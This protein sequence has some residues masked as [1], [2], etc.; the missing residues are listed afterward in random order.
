MKMKSLKAQFIGA[1]AMV[2]VA[3]IAMGS[4]TYAWFAMNTE[5]RAQNMTVQAT[6]E[7][8]LIISNVNKSNWSSYADAQ[9]QSATALVPTSHGIDTGEDD[10]WYHNSS[11]DSNNA[12][13]YAGAYTDLTSSL[14]YTNTSGTLSYGI[15]YIEGGTGSGADAGYSAAQDKAYHLK[16]TFFI[17]TSAEE[18]TTTNL[19]IKNVEVTSSGSMIALDASLR[20]AIVAGGN[21]YIYSPIASANGQAPTYTYAVNSNSTSTSTYKP[22]AT[23]T[24]GSGAGAYLAGKDLACTGVTAIPAYTTETPLQVDIYVYYEGEDAACKS[25]NI[26]GVTVDALT[27]AVT[28]TSAAAA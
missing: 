24:G 14:A 5:V 17:K 11:K 10:G 22:D 2:L 21:T 28:F 26:N 8:G 16:N 15:G 20:V 27:V 13:D 4:S 9:V 18:M 25:A 1:I 3:A 7:G 6:S 19:V 12:V 23:S